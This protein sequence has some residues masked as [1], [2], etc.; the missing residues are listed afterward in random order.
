[1]PAQ[2]VKYDDLPEE[3]RKIVIAYVKHTNPSHT[4]P[5][6]AP[7][8]DLINA[9]PDG[10]HG[11]QLHF[12][13]DALKDMRA[14]FEGLNSDMAELQTVIDEN[15]AI[16]KNQSALPKKQKQDEIRKEID[17][18]KVNLA[19]IK[20]AIAAKKIEIEKNFCTAALMVQDVCKEGSYLK[21]SLLASKILPKDLLNNNAIMLDALKSGLR[22]FH[23][24]LFTQTMGFN[25]EQ[26]KNTPDKD[27]LK[28]WTKGA[29][30]YQ[31]TIIAVIKD[32]VGKLPPAPSRDS[33]KKAETAKSI[34]LRVIDP[35]FE[36]IVTAIEHAKA[37]YDGLN[38]GHATNPER[39]YV[40]DFLDDAIQALREKGQALKKDIDSMQKQKGAP[41][42]IKKARQEASE[43]IRSQLLG[44]VQLVMSQLEKIYKRARTGSD[45]HKVL[46]A[47][48]YAY[49]PEGIKKAEIVTYIVAGL[50][51]VREFLAK[52]KA[53][54]KGCLLYKDSRTAFEKMISEASEMWFQHI[55]TF[56][57]DNKYAQLDQ[58][59]ERMDKQ[60]AQSDTA[61]T[62]KTSWI[63]SV[64]S[65][66]QVLFWGSS[67]KELLDAAPVAASVP[68]KDVSKGKEVEEP[69]EEVADNSTSL[70]G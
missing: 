11:P 53:A 46:Q 15:E 25:S 49:H 19:A 1:M 37:E 26:Y 59:I 38:H 23:G 30:L 3:F 47:V 9:I 54:Q 16:L 45:T 70:T 12:L 36:D 57:E 52:P 27:V 65:V 40:W 44:C 10:Y 69:E 35:D 58:Y 7:I 62:Q 51:F 32:L 20:E 66:T 68:S 64:K 4:L 8:E 18:A 39:L 13:N 17:E 50:D 43:L 60:V 63:P 6:S 21:K 31:S 56:H 29:G 33:G 5:P 67:K 48:F 22:Y 14:T 34:N 2:F 41:E 55:T 42:A 24:K 28:L 61:K